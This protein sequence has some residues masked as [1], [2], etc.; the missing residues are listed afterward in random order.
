MFAILIDAAEINRAEH[1]IWDDDLP[2]FG[3]RVLAEGEA[4]GSN[5]L[6]KG[7]QMG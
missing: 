7:V 5:V 4:L 2:G 1:F 3:L 6:C